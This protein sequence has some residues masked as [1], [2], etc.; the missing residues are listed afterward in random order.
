MRLI[1]Q[2]YDEDEDDYYFC[3][4]PSNGAPLEWNWQGKTEVLGDLSLCPTWTDP[5]SNPGLRG[6]RPAANRVSH[7]TALDYFCVSCFASVLLSGT[8]PFVLCVPV[9]TCSLRRIIIDV[10]V[11]HGFFFK[12]Y[13]RDQ[14]SGILQKP[15]DRPMTVIMLIY[16][17]SI[18]S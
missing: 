4:F 9:I 3:P 12:F 15:P 16:C 17:S 8:L 1:V 2:P 6:G 7:G 18:M 14:L 5:G 11:F 10:M 13:R